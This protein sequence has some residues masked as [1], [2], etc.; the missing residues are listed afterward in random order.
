VAGRT[1]REGQTLSLNYRFPEE[2]RDV[3]LEKLL[4]AT[5]DKILGTARDKLREVTDGLRD[6][7]RDKPRAAEPRGPSTEAQR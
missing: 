2:T 3:P 7:T 5:G 6:L 4:E 1:V